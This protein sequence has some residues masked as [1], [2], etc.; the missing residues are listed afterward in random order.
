MKYLRLQTQQEIR[1]ASTLWF[2]IGTLVGG[3]VVYLWR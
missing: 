2:W 3:A 1:A